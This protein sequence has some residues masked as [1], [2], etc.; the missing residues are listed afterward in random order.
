MKRSIAVLIVVAAALYF[1]APLFAQG[2]RGRLHSGLDKMKIRRSKSDQGKPGHAGGKNITDHL[3]DNPKLASKLEKLLSTG[4]RPISSSQLQQDAQG[5]KNLGQFV[6]AVHVSKNLG[7]SFSD[8]KS[9]MLGP[10]PESLG[11]CIQDMKPGVNAKAEVKKAQK[12]AHDDIEDTKEAKT[13]RGT[14]SDQKASGGSES[15]S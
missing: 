2:L 14:D 12:Q 1:G 8:L 9:T 7:I 15:G 11:K 13:K 5:F 6:A 3:Q 10:P 4:K